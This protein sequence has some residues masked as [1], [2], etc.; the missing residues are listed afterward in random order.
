VSFHFRNWLKHISRNW[1]SSW[2][3]LKIEIYQ[4]AAAALALAKNSERNCNASHFVR[5]CQLWPELTAGSGYQVLDRGQGQDRSLAC[6]AR[7]GR[8][9]GWS[10]DVREN[11][12]IKGRQAGAGSDTTGCRELAQRQTETIWVTNFEKWARMKFLSAAKKWI[13]VGE[14]GQ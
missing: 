2:K 7:R 9:R 12:E 1:L 4:V 13:L 11:L 6:R 3:I 10:P 5:V 8:Q 14:A